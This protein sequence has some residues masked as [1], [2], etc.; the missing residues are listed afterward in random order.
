MV[1]QIAYIHE[2]ESILFR[3]KERIQNKYM[4]EEDHTL[5]QLPS[6][7]TV[8]A[9]APLSLFLSIALPFS[10]LILLSLH[11]AYLLT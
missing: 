1:R 9:A 8:M 4:E 5:T 10:L 11:G 2:R 3:D 6:L 7:T